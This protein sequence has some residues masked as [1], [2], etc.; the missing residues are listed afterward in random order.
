MD[1]GTRIALTTRRFSQSMEEILFS[2]KN[3][4]RA[5]RLAGLL[6]ASADFWTEGGSADARQVHNKSLRVTQQAGWTRAI[7]VHHSPRRLSGPS[8]RPVRFWRCG[9]R[10]YAG[11]PYWLLAA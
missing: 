1:Q 3:H 9:G 4:E 8:P 6:L 7:A 5:W 2:R 11:P 10:R